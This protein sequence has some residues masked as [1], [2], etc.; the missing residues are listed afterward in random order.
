M[1]NDVTGTRNSNGRIIIIKNA[2]FKEKDILKAKAYM[3]V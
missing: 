3:R 2:K 1:E